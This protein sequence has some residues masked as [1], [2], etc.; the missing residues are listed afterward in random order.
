MATSRSGHGWWPY[1]L[2][3]FAFLGLV[4]LS[5]RFPEAAQPLFLALKVAV[6]GGLFVL[7]RARGAYPELR[8]YP[9]GRAGALLDFG[10]GVLGGAVWMAPFV[11]L[12][13]LRSP[14]WDALPGFLRPS[15]E[16]A[17]DPGLMGPDRIALTLG[18]RALGYAVV[19]PFVEE[20]FVRSW[21]M[22]YAEVF[23]RPVDFR[24]VP[25]A[26]Y[27]RRSFLTVLVFFTASHAPW[28][29]P[30]AVLWVVGSQ[31]W[32]Y[33]RRHLGSLVW[34]H[35]GSNASIFVAVLLAAGRLTDRAGA[36]LDLWFFL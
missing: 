13:W 14:L 34:L 26:R 30:V 4:E 17:F 24:D 27:S 33:R 22:R 28:E 5:G 7:F 29:W 19:T 36:P 10:V 35:A 16:D 32:F 11:V 3:L 20:L 6:P 2:P 8:G 15:P 1:L 23:D 12:L 9:H 21:L 31:L 25:I 18:L